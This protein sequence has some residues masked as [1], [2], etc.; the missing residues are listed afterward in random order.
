MTAV[1]MSAKE[2][3][4]P[5]VLLTIEAGWVSIREACSVLSLR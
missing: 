5:D 2:F 4:W 3:I 1:S